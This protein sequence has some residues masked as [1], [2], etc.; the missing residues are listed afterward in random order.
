MAKE[1]AIQLTFVSLRHSGFLH[2][3]S[4]LPNQEAVSIYLTVSDCLWTS[5]RG[6]KFQKE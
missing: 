4:S 5:R 1:D 2:L 3:N 6:Q